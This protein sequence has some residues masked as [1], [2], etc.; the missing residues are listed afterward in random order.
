MRTPQGH[1]FGP[2][3]SADPAALFELFPGWRIVAPSTPAEYVG[4][5][6][7]A[8]HCPDP[9]LVI[10][11]HR[12]WQLKGPV[13]EAD[14]DYVLPPARRGAFGRARTCPSWPGPSGSTAYRGLPTSLPTAGSMP[15]SSIFGGLT[16]R[17]STER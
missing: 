15:R 11:H 4:L 17:V 3:H 13:P 10:E 16:G 9:G 14:L 8:M 2:Q 5:F 7:A 12:L 1:G 6:N